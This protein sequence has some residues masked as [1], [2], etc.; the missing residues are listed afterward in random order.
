MSREMSFDYAGTR[1]ALTIRDMAALK[2]AVAGRLAA[3]EGFA[4]ATLN[5]DHMVKLRSDAS[6]R[7][8][9]ARHELVTADGHPVAWLARL[10]GRRVALVPGSDAV[11]P[12]ARMAM[13]EGAP[14]G[15]FGSSQVVLDQVR[16]RLAEELPGLQLVF[17]EAPPMG[18]DPDSPE[19]EAALYRMRASGARLVFLALGAPK[20]ER[21]AAR[22]RALVPELGFVSVGAGLDFLAGGQRRAPRLLRRLS[23]EWLWRMLGAPRR[24][25]PRYAR[26]AAILPGE[27]RRALALRG[28]D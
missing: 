11:L 13:T 7:A 2:R 25:A 9:Y 24:L 18:F 5:L 23:L 17:A 6:F 28:R 10:A 16:A 8:A 12:L 14:L 27:A 4:V 1:V 15:L 20:Q 22:G 3:G 21:L 26:C 19:A